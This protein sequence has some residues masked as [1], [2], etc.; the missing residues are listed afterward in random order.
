[1]GKDEKDEKYTNTKKES[2]L[3]EGEQGVNFLITNEEERNTFALLTCPPD[4]AYNGFLACCHRILAGTARSRRFSPDVVPAR[5]TAV[6]LCTLKQL[7]LL[8]AG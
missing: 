4:I 7:P 1:M 3:E 5:T 6:L 2:R 8:H